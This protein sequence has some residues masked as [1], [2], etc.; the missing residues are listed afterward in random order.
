[1]DEGRALD[2]GRAVTYAVLS[3]RIRLTNAD[4]D[5]LAELLAADGVDNSALSLVAVDEVGSMPMFGFAASRAGVE[6]SSGIAAADVSPTELV[7]YP[8]PADETELGMLLAVAGVPAVRAAW[9]AWRFP[10]DGAPW[11]RPRRVWVIEAD[12]D[13]DLVQ[14]TGQLLGVLDAAGETDGQIETYAVGSDLPSYQL[15]ARTYGAL[16]WTREPGQ[17]LRVATVLTHEGAALRHRPVLDTRESARVAG[18]LSDGVPVLHTPNR[19]DD[20]IDSS[21]RDVVSMNLVTD[22]A[23]V[24]CEA[25]R[26]YLDRYRLAP[27]PA[28]LAHIRAC[29]YRVPLVDGA[30]LYRATQL[31]RDPAVTAHIWSARR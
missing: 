9:R 15:L 10:P 2:V 4:I 6:T 14:I 31:V 23:F 19:L 3:Q 29:R 5:L 22:G 26:Y 18:Y 12:T 27:D 21:R 24:W 8:R 30:A 25:I 16:M 20:V 7:A 17:P 11:P 13:A 28:L 1:L